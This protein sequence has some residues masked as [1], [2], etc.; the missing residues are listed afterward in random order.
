MFG[1]IFTYAVKPQDALGYKTAIP[2][3][4]AFPENELFFA[5]FVWIQTDWMMSSS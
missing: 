5:E 4:F 3:Y 1:S 2:A